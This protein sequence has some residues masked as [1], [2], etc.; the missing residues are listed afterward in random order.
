MP[1]QIIRNDI[2]RVSADA[3]VNTANPKPIFASGTDAAIYT[4]AGATDLLA[5]RWKIG[6]IAPGCA[7]STPAFAL[8][9]KYIIHTV[10][11]AW[12]DGEHG[13]Y[14]TVRSCYENSLRLAKELGCASIAFPLIATGIYGFPKAEALQIAISVFSAFLAKDDMQ[15]TLVVFDE[16]SFVLSGKIFAG[17]DE[18]IDKN[19]VEAHMEAEY[20]G[21]A[22]SMAS[23]DM[24]PASRPMMPMPSA[25]RTSAHAKN[26]MSVET[27]GAVPISAAEYAADMD[28]AEELCKSGSDKSGSD[29]SR[30]KRSLDDVMAQVKES[31]QESLLR[32]IDEKGFT[33]VE[34]YK[35]A[36]VDRKLFSKIRS[37]PS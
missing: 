5:E 32:L 34:I 21:A 23:M 4:A 15:I 19:Y 12:I 9:A 27:A 8:S 30:S 14:E 3:I 17:V 26:A 25:R 7:A 22:A 20:F 33:D 31:W 11:P 2:T 10:G 37:N 6:D 16:D 35:R 24:A 18:Y 1:F 13:E 28:V 29:K 36:N